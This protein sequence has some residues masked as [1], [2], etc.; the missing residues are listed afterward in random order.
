MTWGVRFTPLAAEDV[1]EA[2][3]DYEAA[4]GRLGEEFLA[5]VNGCWI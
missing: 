1:A 5:E 2:Y 4:R 3:G